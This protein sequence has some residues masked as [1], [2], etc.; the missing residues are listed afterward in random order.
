MFDLVQY[1]QHLPGWATL[2]TRDFVKVSGL[3]TRK[4]P[5]LPSREQGAGFVALR[6]NYV[7]EAIVFLD[8]FARNFWVAENGFVL[9][10]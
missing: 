1:G 7:E 10:G 4:T 3:A 6:T 8:D 9:A 2:R 5:G